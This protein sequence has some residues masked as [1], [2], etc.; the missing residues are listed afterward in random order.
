MTPSNP[1]IPDPTC[2][3]CQA[4]L[5]LGAVGGANVW[6][7]PNGHGVACTLTAAYGRLQDDE[8]KKI[9]HESENASVGAR[10]CPMCGRPMVE[11][12][13]GV[14]T[15]EAADGEAGDG[16]DIATVA[17]DVCRY[18]EVFWLDAGELDEFPQDIPTPPPSEQD[19][20]NLEAVRQTII[21]GLDEGTSSSEVPVDPATPPSAPGSAAPS[22]KPD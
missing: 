7:C 19:L 10:S 22:Q 2:P 11:V 20:K 5:A 13:I 21:A 12:S 1:T 4:V 14:D 6:S 15:D 8:I 17:V 18:D 3:T 16:A 9:W